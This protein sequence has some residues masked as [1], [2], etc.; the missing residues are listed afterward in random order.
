M[1]WIRSVKCSECEEKG[2]R[3]KSVYVGVGGRGCRAWG[4]PGER[5]DGQRDGH[6]KIVPESEGF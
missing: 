6:V 3:Q 4:I 2:S 1:A 5:G